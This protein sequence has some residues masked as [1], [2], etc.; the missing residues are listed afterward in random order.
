MNPNPSKVPYSGQMVVLE[1]LELGGVLKTSRKQDP[2]SSPHL[3]TGDKADL[4]PTDCV[5]IILL[6]CGFYHTSF[7]LVHMKLIVFKFEESKLPIPGGRG[8]N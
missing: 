6:A 7:S 4:T 8:M 5:L 3:R 1:V 2:K